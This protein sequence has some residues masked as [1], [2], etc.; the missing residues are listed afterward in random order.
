M[1]KLLVMNDLLQ[2]GGVERLM[3]D[4][5]NY[6]H[7][8][9]EITV[10][11]KEY[12]DNY[13]NLLPENVEYICYGTMPYWEENGKLSQTVSKIRHKLQIIN[14]SNKIKQKHFDVLLCMKEG[15]TMHDALIFCKDIPHKIAWVHT[16]YSKSYYT[17]DIYQTA[18]AERVV[19][20]KFNRVICVS[21]IIEDS[22]KT[23]IGNPGNLVVRYNPLDK[24]KI[25]RKS[26]EPVEDIKRKE[27]PLFVSVGRLNVQKGYDILLEV[28]N[29]LNADGFE[30]DVWIIG[31][32]EASNH[33]QVLHS[34]EDQIRR[35][36]LDNVY[37][38][39]AKD[40]PHKYVREGDWFLSSSRYEGYSYVSQEAAIVG[41]PL[42]LTECSGVLELLGSEENG[43]V[44]ENSVKGIYYGM[45]RTMEH[46]ELA[47][48]YTGKV[49]VFSHREY[50]DDRM[51]EIESLFM[52][53]E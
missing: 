13:A 20:Q 12:D 18:E 42:M 50:L 28:C 31:G 37:L 19:M 29:L 41:K 24:E 48:E 15:W 49:K 3:L 10:F 22:I 53:D 51:Q 35:Y 8:K 36:H 6:F 33:Y 7:D 27:R 38:L 47:K 45:R 21:K 2:G 52:E 44:M 34:L 5:V 32:G 16:D 43:I 9:Y 11:T 25:I 39:G 46:P 30:Y 40:N 1:K 26:Q 4:I 14:I 23:V 17:G